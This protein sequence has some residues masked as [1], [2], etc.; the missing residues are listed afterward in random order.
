[1]AQTI[2]IVRFKLAD[3][4]NRDEFIRQ[5][6][7][8]EVDFLMK[9]PGIISRE[10]AM[11]DDGEVLVVLHWEKPEDAQAS[12]DKFVAAPQT[13]TFTALLNMDTFSMTRFLKV[14]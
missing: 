12:M 7:E 13:K 3:L 2:E 4:K 1:M 14:R 6:A 11:T 5:N 10:T 8:M 9:Q